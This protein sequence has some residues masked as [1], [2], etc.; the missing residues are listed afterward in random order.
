MKTQIIPN[1]GTN[2]G[3]RK[4]VLMHQVTA[5]ACASVLAT[6]CTVPDRIPDVVT[7]ILTQG[8]GDC[9]DLELAFQYRYEYP[10]DKIDPVNGYTARIFFDVS[11]ELP[12]SAIFY[13]VDLR[14]QDGFTGQKDT[15][16]KL[17]G[18]A[19]SLPFTWRYNTRPGTDEDVMTSGLNTTQTWGAVPTQTF[20]GTMVFETYRAPG[21]A[22]A[23][24]YEDLLV[25]FYGNPPTSPR[26]G[27]I[28]GC[29]Q[30]VVPMDRQETA[31]RY[32]LPE[33][34]IAETPTSTPSKFSVQQ[35]TEDPWV[36]GIIRDIST[37]AYGGGGIEQ[38][39][40][41]DDATIRY[42]RVLKIVDAALVDSFGNFIGTQADLDAIYDEVN[43]SYYADVN[44]WGAN[45][46]IF[47][48]YNDALTT[49]TSSDLLSP[50]FYNSGDT[51]AI[52]DRVY[53]TDGS[54]QERF[55]NILFVKP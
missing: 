48:D 37:T 54:D 39:V 7:D 45:K 52:F 16:I 19:K 22:G 46:V 34:E 3:K 10:T 49:S 35:T 24:Q 6:G 28:I 9:G 12:S 31:I 47:F 53:T 38:N 8:T 33:F 41:F 44:Q 30:L 27:P 5:F 23:P 29:Q 32:Y 21:M 50:N 4:S 42:T 17:S 14:L 11:A 36:M 1:K 13:D 15:A 20:I 40:F 51:W 25:N 2:N 43:Q 55:S 18:D 26:K